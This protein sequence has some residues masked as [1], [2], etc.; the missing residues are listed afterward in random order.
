[1]AVVEVNINGR[2]Y[3]VVCADGQQDRV[4]EMARHVDDTLRSIAGGM[5]STVNDT[6][7]LVLTS[8]LMADTITD[9]RAEAAAQAAAPAEDPA[10]AAAV[11]ALSQRVEDLA[12]RLSGT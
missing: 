2:Y 8:L 3:P 4:R 7:L 5:G 12:A 9:L 10:L 1:M 11:D 6:H